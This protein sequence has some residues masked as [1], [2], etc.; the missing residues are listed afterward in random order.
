[1]QVYP[2]VSLL[3]IIEY[4][5]TA[6]TPNF[7]VFHV[8]FLVQLIM[9]FCELFLGPRLLW[10]NF[11]ILP[12]CGCKN[13]IISMVG[14]NIFMLIILVRKR[15]IQ[16]LLKFEKMI[17]IKKCNFIHRRPDTQYIF[18]KKCVKEYSIVIVNS[19]ALVFSFS[20][21]RILIPWSFN[22]LFICLSYF[23]LSSPMF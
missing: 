2:I 6:A 7:S 14:L 4:I 13:N 11:H 23:F 12:I 9:D 19:M 21:L 8:K 1:M 15:T 5:L 18:V 16:T 20:S 17:A 3:F 22:C 10:L